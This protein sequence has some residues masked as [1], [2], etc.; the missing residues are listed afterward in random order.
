VS[1]DL[2]WTRIETL[3]SPDI[4][5][6]ADEDVAGDRLRGISQIAKFINESERRTAYLV[7][8]SIIPVGR[9]G[10]SIIASKE[11]LRRYHR[12]MTSGGEA[13]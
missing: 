9:E 5:S 3:L 7:Q 4:F 1:A 13:A 12:E 10:T 2:N 11:R 8:K 6:A